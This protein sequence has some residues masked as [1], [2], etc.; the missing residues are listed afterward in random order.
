MDLY[1]ADVS[2]ILPS[3]KEHVAKSLRRIVE[4]YAAL[5]DANPKQGFDAKATEWQKRLEDLNAAKKR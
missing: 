4:L 2:A 1:P 5:N 3:P